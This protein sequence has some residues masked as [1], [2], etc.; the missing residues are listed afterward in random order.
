MRRPPSRAAEAG[1]H[2]LV[3]KPVCYTVAE[4]EAMADA[5]DRAG[6]VSTRRP[7]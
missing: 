2:I 1:K 3:E 5:A 4:A 6:V 7:T